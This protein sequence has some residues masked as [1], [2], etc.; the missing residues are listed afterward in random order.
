MTMEATIQAL[1]VA[2]C[3]RT[4]QTVAKS[5]ATRPYVVWQA[6]GGRTMRNLENTA[7]DKRNTLVQV[8]VWA[9]NSTDAVT[10]IRQYEEDLCAATGLTVEPLGEAEGTFDEDT[11]FYGAIQ[12]FSIY[13]TR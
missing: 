6:F 7:M 4:W 11:K 1:F 9:D 10:L 3:A 8:S 13:S 5:I 12:R 2:R